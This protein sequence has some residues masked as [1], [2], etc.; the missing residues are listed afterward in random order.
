MLSQTIWCHHLLQRVSG[1]SPAN[2]LIDNLLWSER[3][4]L[5]MGE[6]LLIARWQWQ[7]C[8][9]IQLWRW[10]RKMFK[11]ARNIIAGTYSDAPLF[12]WPLLLHA[13]SPEENLTDVSVT[14]QWQQRKIAK[15]LRCIGFIHRNWFCRLEQT[16]LQTLSICLSWTDKHTS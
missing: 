4:T 16:A 14:G 7:S 5:D 10:K 2:P 12:H 1:C 13:Q 9:V 8:T 15:S 6:Q 11:G 3:C